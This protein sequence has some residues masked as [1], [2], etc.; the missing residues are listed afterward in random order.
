MKTTLI[1]QA[2][3]IFVQNDLTE[4]WATLDLLLVV[5]KGNLCHSYSALP[6]FSETW[7]TLNLYI[8]LLLK[9]VSN[10]REFTVVIHKEGIR[11]TLKAWCNEELV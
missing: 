9:S 11:F 3:L 1:I 8:S 10:Y 5:I 2:T 6:V 7:A 4:I